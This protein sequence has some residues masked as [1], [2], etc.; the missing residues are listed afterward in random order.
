MC[1]KQVADAVFSRGEDGSALDAVVGI[2]QLD[3]SAIAS[4]GTQKEHNDVSLKLLKKT[5][6]DRGQITRCILSKSS[7]VCYTSSMDGNM[8]VYDCKSHQFL[9]RMRI[10]AA[11]I[12]DMDVSVNL[13]YAVASIADGKVHLIDLV[14]K[15]R[16]QVWDTIS[17]CATAVRFEPVRPQPCKSALAL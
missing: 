14:H 5:S 12:T 16:L 8:C 9:A 3:I 4:I 13:D 1:W 10:H 7:S 2:A 11:G 15:K 17:R 6:D